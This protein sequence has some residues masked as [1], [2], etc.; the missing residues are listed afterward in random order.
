MVSVLIVI[1]SFISVTVN[2][3]MKT[4]IRDYTYQASEIDSKQS[5]RII[6]TEQVKRLLLE[7]LGTYL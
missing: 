4:F 6:A 3:E 7:E 1:F 5:S 2:A